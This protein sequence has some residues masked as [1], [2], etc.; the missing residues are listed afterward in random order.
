MKKYTDRQLKRLYIQ[1]EQPGLA[2]CGTGTN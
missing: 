1:S 2:L